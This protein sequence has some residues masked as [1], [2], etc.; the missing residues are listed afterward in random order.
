MPAVRWMW[1][2]WLQVVVTR[3][4][5]WLI[6]RVRT[7]TKQRIPLSPHTHRNKLSNAGGRQVQYLGHHGQVQRHERERRRVVTLLGGEAFPSWLSR[8]G[9]A[10]LVSYA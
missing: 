5:L 7:T 2:V 8:K 4:V 6:M 9:K 10:L 3:T 1:A